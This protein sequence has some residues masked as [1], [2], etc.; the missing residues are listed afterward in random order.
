[1]ETWQ[2]GLVILIAL[3]IWGIIS[4]ITEGDDIF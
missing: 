2:I 3:F 1:M 4:S